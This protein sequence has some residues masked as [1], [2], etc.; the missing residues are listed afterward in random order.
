MIARFAYSPIPSGDCISLEMLW[1]DERQLGTLHIPTNVLEMLEGTDYEHIHAG[2]TLSLPLALGLGVV[3][4]ALT[5][6]D[7]QLGGDRTA[8]LDEWGPLETVSSEGENSPSQADPMRS[9]PKF[10]A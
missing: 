7:L 5:L 2:E 8:W 6:V 9:T 3:L 1:R 4:A 10:D